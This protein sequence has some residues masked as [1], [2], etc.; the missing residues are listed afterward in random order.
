MTITIETLTPAIGAKITG[1]DL[2]RGLD[3]DAFA[4]VHE[5]ALNH[6]MLYFPG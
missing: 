1:V 6:L 2:A 3:V 4:L 5:A